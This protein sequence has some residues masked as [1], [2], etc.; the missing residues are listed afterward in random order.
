MLEI[1]GA[2]SKGKA[3]KDWHEVW[4]SS[5]ESQEIQNELNRIHEAK[6]HEAI[7]GSDV[8]GQR[9][10]AMPFPA[11]LYHVTKR[12][13]QQY[14]RTPSYIWGKLLLGILAALFI[15]FSFYKSDTSQQG[16]QNGIFSV[17]MLTNIFSTL[18][19]QVCVPYPPPF[20]TFTHDDRS[21]PSS[22]LSALCTKCASVLPKPTPGKL[23]SWLISLSKFHG[24][25]YSVSSFLV[26]TT[27][28]IFTKG[29]IPSSERQGL[30]LLY[31]IQFFIYGSTFAH[32]LIAGLPDAETAGNLATFLF[33]MTLVF[34]GVMQSPQN[35]PGFWIFMY[36][37]SPLTYW[38]GGVV[39]TG[40]G[41]KMVKCAPNELA[42][43]NPPSGQTCGQYLSSYLKTAPGQLLDPNATSQCQYCPL[44][45]SDQ[46][47]SSV[48]MNYTQRWRNYGIVWAYVAFNIF[49]AVAF[50]YCFRVAGF[51][52]I[53]SLE[54]LKKMWHGLRG[55]TGKLSEE[56]R[57]TNEHIL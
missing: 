55:K 12:V 9:E 43:F 31:I 24:K 13:F 46:F 32:A 52:K 19:Q 1:A 40:L 34:N 22:L 10:F 2:G 56:D 6:K 17:F 7:A 57:K 38:V 33:A 11:Q 28:P 45:T 29:G 5:P 49:I 42:I 35:L 41:G 37:V 16:L 15:G 14:W 21:C 50:Y 39:S 44:T 3:V 30:V 48:S 23:S 8:E 26:A 18:V 54:P 20:D 4:K 25:S 51:K 27:T 36:R 47:L 53:I